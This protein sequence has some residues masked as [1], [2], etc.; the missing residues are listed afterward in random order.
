MI[1]AVTGGRSFIDK[2]LLIEVLSHYKITQILHG[3]CTGADK[4]A[5]EWATNNGIEVVL[6]KADWDQYGAIAGPVRNA[7]MLRNGKPDL[8]IAFTGGS[9]TANCK[10]QAKDL[11]IPVVVIRN[12]KEKVA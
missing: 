7:K 11:G 2:A 5:A 4:M 10:A 1:V 6:F 3:G 9:G 8:L 12:T